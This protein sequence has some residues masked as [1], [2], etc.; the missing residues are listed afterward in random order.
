MA[1]TM[2]NGCD[3]YFEVVGAG[4]PVLFMHGAFGGLGTGETAKEPPR[5]R[6][7]LARQHTVI[8]YDRRSF[9]RSSRSTGALSLELF[10][11]DARELLRHVDVPRAI[12]WGESAGSPIAAQFAVDHPDMVAALVLT[13]AMPWLSPDADL[14]AKLRARVNLLESSGPEAAYE[15]RRAHGAVGLDIYSDTAAAGPASKQR[16]VELAAIREELKAT[17]R[18]ARVAGYADELRTFAAYLDFDLTGLL[19]RLSMPVLIV[20]GA[21][22]R[23]F[24]GMDWA[25]L[26]A[27]KDNVRFRQLPGA[28]HGVSRGPDVIELVEPFLS[29]VLQGTPPQSGGPA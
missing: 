24:P 7:R 8:T 22:D 4:F 17:S 23:V 13:D 6:D 26:V 1:R 16:E 9:G 18:E 14:V 29:E 12:V 20:C 2:A 25:A 19:E 15:A 10:A 3:T 21:E 27:K 28:G 5:W 11:T